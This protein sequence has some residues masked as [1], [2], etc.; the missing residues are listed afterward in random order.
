MIMKRAA[1]IKFLIKI[2]DTV[3]E[4]N[5]LYEECLAR[6]SDYILQNDE[7]SVEPDFIVDI[8]PRN[9]MR[10]NVEYQ[11]HFR[12]KSAPLLYYDPGYLE[13]F[14]V[15]RKI[16][17]SIPRFGA[18]L[19]HGTVVAYK[20]KGFMFTAPSGVGKSTRAKLWLEEF[21]G[22]V[23]IN[24]DKPFLRAHNNSVYAYG[25]PWCGKE[26][27]NKNIGVPLCGIF[28]LERADE[29]HESNL[30]ELCFD[31][32]YLEML[33]HVYKPTDPISLSMTLKLLLELKGR[34]IV[35]RFRSTNTRESVRLAWEVA[36]NRMK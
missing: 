20:G 17:E 24:G 31:E 9:I 5:T 19:M 22:S 10:E 12:N 6:C 34:V 33:N 30:E 3:I 14:V 23:V 1:K 7:Y 28:L 2:A 21:P 29:G 25:S 4:V 15:Q 26:H 16:S 36:T 32:A 13:H 11:S 27:W 8:V 18:F 35:Y